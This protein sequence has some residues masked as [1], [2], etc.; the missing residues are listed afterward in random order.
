ML[1][2]LYRVLD[3]MRHRA[4]LRSGNHAHAWGKH[5]EDL[6]MRYLQNR[7]YTA[8]AR[9]YRSVG[10]GAEVDLVALDQDT[11]VFVEVK[12][13]YSDEFGPPDSAVDLAKRRKILRGAA[14]FLRRAGKTDA[15]VRFDLVNVVFAEGEVVEHIP[16][17]FGREAQSS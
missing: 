9:N 2:A 8:V 4:R 10:G 3:R 16:D 17:A 11:L 1:R 12:T 15:L 14:D 6:A 5:G 7:G 13:R